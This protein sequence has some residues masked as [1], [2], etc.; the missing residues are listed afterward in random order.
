MG[1]TLYNAGAAQA[2]QLFAEM[3]LLKVHQV[4]VEMRPLHDR[5]KRMLPLLL[6]LLSTARNLARLVTAF[7]AL[8]G[9]DDSH[10]PHPQGKEDEV[11]ERY[12]ELLKSA[13]TIYGRRHPAVASA[14]CRLARV[15]LEQ[16]PASQIRRGNTSCYLA[17]RD[18]YHLDGFV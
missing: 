15:L 13:K 4:G 18:T 2:D 6:L 8:C 3:V 16:V 9:T 17:R 1:N 11:V 5:Y 7:G 14:L 12:E 10:E